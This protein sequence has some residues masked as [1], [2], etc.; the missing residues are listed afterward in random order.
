VHSGELVDNQIHVL[1]GDI[2]GASERTGETVAL[3]EVE[4]RAPVVP[5]KVVAIGWNYVGHAD[6]LGVLQPTDPLMFLKA[7]SAVIGPND[8][9]V[10][11][12]FSSQLSYEGELVAVIGDEC[13]DVP[14][15]E[16]LDHIFGWTVGN[17]VTDREIQK[18]EVQYARSKSFNTFCPLGPW[19]DT[20]FDSTSFHIETRVNGDLTQSG[21]IELMIHKV[22]EI[23]AWVSRA[24]TLQRGDVIMTGTPK[25][26]GIL[27][28]GDHVC[29]SIEGLG[30]LCNAVVEED[31]SAP[32][33]G[34][35]RNRISEG[36]S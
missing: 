27:Q 29:V 14:A 36:Q 8:D 13:V 23:I 15:E 34:G 24:I 10:R 11:P 5:S 19:V 7:P 20:D 22:P 26:V 16:A 30:S 21:G 18:G 12:K 31:E 1:A 35:L 6:E 4:L 3:G 17:D 2:F 9:I 25:G 33:L 32:T 28:P